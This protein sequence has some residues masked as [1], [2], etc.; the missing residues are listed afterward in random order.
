MYNDYP[1]FPVI[2]YINTILLNNN[3]INMFCNLFFLWRIIIQVPNYYCTRDQ[4]AV[5]L[6]RH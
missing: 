5:N 4:I 3:L 2:Y 6:S 1:D